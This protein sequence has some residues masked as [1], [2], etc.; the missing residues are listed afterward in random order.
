[1]K[2]LTHPRTPTLADLELEIAHSVDH[3]FDPRTQEGLGDALEHD[4][5]HPLITPSG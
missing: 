2:S 1:V 5:A 3:Y 4:A